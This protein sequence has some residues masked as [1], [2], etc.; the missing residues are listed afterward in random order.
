MKHTLK[1][2]II[3]S[4][5]L[6]VAVGVTVSGASASTAT[7][8]TGKW[9]PPVC[10]TGLLVAYYVSDGFTFNDDLVI[11]ADGQ[12]WLCW[13]RHISTTSGEETFTVSQS[14]LA[15]LESTLARIGIERL[16][17]SPRQPCCDMPTA[18]LVYNGK[19]IPYGGYPESHA[20]LLALRSAEAIL[21]GIIKQRS[22]D[23]QSV[24]SV[25]AVAL[26]AD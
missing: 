23:H 5:V 22:P 11:G 1:R 2:R 21:N 18:S 12:A 10:P 24:R 3:S 16:G 6:A 17:A 4:V 13:G 9:P 20:G 19:T 7:A 8:Q 15:T 14:K 25:E 26:G